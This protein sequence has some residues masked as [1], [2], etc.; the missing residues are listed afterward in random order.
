[1]SVLNHWIGCFACGGFFGAEVYHHGFSPL[2]L[3]PVA[4]FVGLNVTA[5]RRLKAETA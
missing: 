1:V 4:C 3:I 2:L 5:F